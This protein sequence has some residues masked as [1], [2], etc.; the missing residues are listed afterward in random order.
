MHYSI[1][2]Q[3]YTNTNKTSDE[4]YVSIKSIVKEYQIEDVIISSVVPVITSALKKVFVK[5]YHKEPMILGPGI[6]TFDTNCSN[7][8]GGL[9]SNVK[10]TKAKNKQ[11][12]HN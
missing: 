8:L 7:I 12:G 6:K 2:H 1:W 4:Y 3:I 11:T 5:L 9:S 10:E